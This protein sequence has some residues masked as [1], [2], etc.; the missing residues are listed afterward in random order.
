MQC[1]VYVNYKV[2]GKWLFLSL[3]VIVQVSSLQPS[4]CIRI[5]W[6]ALKTTDVKD[7]PCGAN[8]NWFG[9]GPRHL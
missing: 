2:P 1:I 6:T 9:V 5:T 4:L 8:L 3:S 7:A